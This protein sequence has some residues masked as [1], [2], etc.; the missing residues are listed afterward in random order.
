[1]LEMPREAAHPLAGRPSCA[2]SLRFHA[3]G[4]RARGKVM[5]FRNGV[6]A[7][8]SAAAGV[9]VAAEPPLTVGEPVIVTATRIPQKLSESNQHVVVITR[10]E[11]SASGHTSLVEL[12]QARGG[13]EVTSNGG[14]GQPS[15]VFMRGAE[16]RHTM[17]LIDGLRIGSA[18]A[19]G[20]AFENIP[21]SQIDRIEIVP[22]S[23]SSL[24]GSDAIGGVIQIFTRRDTTGG[25]ARFEAGSFGTRGLSSAYGRRVTDSDFSISAGAIES[26]AFD[27][28]KP[29]IPFAQ[30]NPDSDRY[31]N[32]NFSAR[33]VQNLAGGH[34][35]GAT[36]FYSEGAAHFDAGVATDDVNR[37]T[38][39]AGSVYSRNRLGANWTSLVRLGTTRDDSATVGA[40]PGYFRTD[41][42]QATWQNDVQLPLGTAVAGLEYLDQR[43]AS[44]TVFAQTRRPIKSAFAG[45]RGDHD[46]HALQVN[47]RHDDNSQFGEHNT[48]SLGYSYRFT[49][50]LRVRAGAG[51]AFKA[52]TFND[53]YFPDQPPFFFSN[54]NLRPERSRSREAGFDYDGAQQH[55]AVTLFQTRITDLITIFTDPVTFVSTTQNLNRVRIEGL[56]LSYHGTLRSWQTRAQVTVQDPRDEAT[57]AQLRRRA[58]HYGSV[59][60]SRPFGEWRLGAEVIGSGERFD[61][62]NEAL[63]TRLHDY[64]LL[65]LMMG[66]SLSRDWSLN[67]RWNNVFDRDYELVQFFNTPGSN[68]FA[69]LA[70]QPR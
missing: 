28:T 25:S 55:L 58:K 13:V 5:V 49:P 6:A 64:G 15:A 33:L 40:F 3:C 37:Q 57:G 10:E 12:L 22:G 1:M 31:R 50:A 24:Y 60:V 46:G 27:A 19:G 23:L 45:Y 51:T 7:V 8:L 54:P 53:L 39:Q 26:S 63:N 68:L 32:R 36:V 69:W 9:V 66:Y 35:F 4:G 62:T 41:Q 48:G 65:N 16:A 44:D 18:T 17:V 43:V 20:T 56:E 61:S 11:I 29:A 52:P 14:L 67:A 38:L 70:W 47:A 21:L 30:H 2:I 42:H 59:A 34:E